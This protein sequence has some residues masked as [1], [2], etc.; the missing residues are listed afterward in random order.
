MVLAGVMVFERQIHWIAK[1]MDELADSLFPG[2][3]LSVEFHASEIFGGRGP[4][5]SIKDS[6][7]RISVITKV[8]EILAESHESV[9]AFACAV[10]KP[11]FPGRDA[12]EM[13]FEDLCSRFDICLK[14]MHVEQSNSQRGLIIL[15]KSTYETSLQKMALNFKSLGTQWGSI[16]NLAEVPLFVDSRSS[17]IVQL[18]DHIAYSVFRRYERGDTKYLDIILSKFDNREGVLHGLAHK[19]NKPARCMCPASMSRGSA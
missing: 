8:L 4:W 1:R 13:A 17:R 15:D 9:Q 7:A 11:S 2:N 5:K 6:K 19:Q 10:H 14:R 16:N 18:A 3:G 12:M